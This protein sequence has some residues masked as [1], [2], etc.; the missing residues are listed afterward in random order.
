MTEEN[1]EQACIGWF[2]ELGWNFT[3]GEAISPGGAHPERE[4]YAQVILACRLRDAL[5]R[6]NPELPTEVLEEAVKRLLQYAGQSL[7]EANREIYTWLRDGIPVEV[8]EDGHRRG[9]SAQVFDFDDPYNNDWLL[10]NQFTVKGKMTCR[11]DLVVFVNGIP[12]AAIELKN[13]ADEDTDVT[14]AFR[15]IQ[16]YKAEIQQ[17]FEPN[18]CC[19]I[20]D[21]TVARVGSIT[22]DEERYMPWRVAEDIEQPE[23]HLELEVLVRGLFSRQ[24]LLDYLRYFVAFQNSGSGVAIKLIAGYHQYHGVRKAAQ[25]AIEA[26]TQRKD[27]KG[28]V[29]WFTQGSGKSLIALFYVCLLRERPE[30]ENPTVVIVTDRNDLDGQMFETFAACRD[31]AAHRA[32]SGTGG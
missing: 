10:V 31:P 18:L 14:V 6:L 1:L 24:T 3:P 12:L 17:L 2:R 21:G 20:S 26:A 11:P 19:V 29:M 16:N 5:S 13:P 32:A 23:Q 8:E 30:L 28:G 9:R 22:A 4:H 7:V 27:G 15:Q 25:R